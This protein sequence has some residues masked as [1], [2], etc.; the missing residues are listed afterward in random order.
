MKVIDGKFGS[1]IKVSN[2]FEAI[3]KEENLDNYDEAFCI[4][5]S[6]DYVV[7]STNLEA[8]D[9]FYLL[10]QIKMSVLTQG[11]YEI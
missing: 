11:D 10:E 7:V 9:L 6:D 3:T 4:I 8:K 2:V 5:K 1:H